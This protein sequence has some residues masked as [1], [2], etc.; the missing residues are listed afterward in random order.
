MICLIPELCYMT[1]LT[2]DMRCD[3]RAMK[4]ISSHTRIKPGVRQAKLTQFIRN[5]N[6]NPAAKQILDNWGL[7]LEETPL[8]TQARTMV[9]DK[10]I[11]GNNLTAHVGP[12]ADWTRDATNKT[13]FHC[14][15]V[16]RWV[17]IITRKDTSRADDF[18]KCLK[19]VTRNMGFNFA[20]PRLHEAK[21]DSAMAYTNAIRESVKSGDQI[22]VLMTPGN[23][24]REDR[25]NAIKRLTFCELHIPSQVVRAYTLSDQKMRSVC[26]KIAIQISCK[27]GGQPWAIPIPFKSC[28]IV[29]IDVYHD[30]GQRGKSVVAVVSSINPAVTRWYSRVY[31]QKTQEEIVNTL[32]SGI[33]SSLKK[34][35]EVNHFLPQRIFIYR[36]GV[37]DGQLS[38]VKDYEIV[39]VENA[40]LDFGKSFQNY[41]PTV[42]LVVVQKR[43][44]TK[45]LMKGRE[46]FENPPPG[47]VLDHSVTRKNYYDFFLISQFVNQG[48]VTPTHY[49]VLYDNN[50]MTP[51]RMQKLAYK[52]SHLYYNW[53]GTIR[54]PAPC[55]VSTHQLCSQYEAIF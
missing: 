51:D 19:Q 20:D 38:V 21:D 7:E 40:I 29:G 35:Y 43:I 36:D 11:F 49:I 13:L 37:G 48:T 4:D 47:S 42:S 14:I 53:P 41:K 46:D 32:E 50:N 27:I 30:G 26:Q 22:V 2:D 24:Q 5:V 39:Q 10:I 16:D 45:I 3:T 17:L 23:S 34:Y 8:V 52:M 44:N 28:M 54:V 33:V 6:T 9:P 12:K 25:Y 1:G 55:Q 15:D 31:F 18:I